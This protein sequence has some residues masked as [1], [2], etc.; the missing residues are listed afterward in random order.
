MQY[1]G[2]NLLNPIDILP[3]EQGNYPN[4]EGQFK[5]REWELPLIFRVGVSVI[6]FVTKDTRLTL[7]VDALHPNNNSESINVGAEYLWDIETFGEIYL[8]GG[9]KGLFM[10]NAQY[11]LSLGGG[12]GMDVMDNIKMMG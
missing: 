4:A 7:A 3:N 9:Y 11:G 8:R 5:L 1:N 12:F 2:M 10:N 6:P